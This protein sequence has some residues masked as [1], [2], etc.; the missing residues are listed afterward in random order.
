[1]LKYRCMTSILIL[2]LSLSPLA[3]AATSGHAEA[4]DE[5]TAQPMAAS[6]EDG[7]EQGEQTRASLVN[8]SGLPS[9]VERTEHFD[10]PGFF[11][12]LHGGRLWVLR[13]GS[14]ALEAFLADGPPPHN[15]IRVGAGPQALSIRAVDKETII[16]YLATKRGFHVELID[17][18]L[19]VLEKDTEEYEAF[20]ADGPGPH[21]VTQVG[22][23]PQN[24]SVRSIDRETLLRYL[25][26]K[27]GFHVEVIDD[28]LWVLEEG[29]EA[30]EKFFDDGPPPHSVTQIGAGPLG[31]SLRAVDRETII[32]YL[33]VKPG[34]HTKLMDGRIWVLRQAS[35]AYEAFKEGGPP[36]HS[37]TRIGA[38]PLQTS[39]RA[40][41]AETIDDYLRT[42]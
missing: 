41:D 3:C 29:T 26:S 40:A 8:E 5:T 1:M 2:S 10:R 39:L 21:S 31:T 20:K 32:A 9:G 12:A 27:P 17:G 15:V 23:G 19:W 4:P 16:E 30:H 13:E 33:A 14:E 7:A 25:G 38:G 37:V 6:A 22:A 11:T 42:Q 36:A 35:K 34:F 24:V 18:R 28:R